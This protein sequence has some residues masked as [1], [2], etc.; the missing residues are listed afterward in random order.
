MTGNRTAEE[1]IGGGL[2][3]IRDVAAF[4]K[5]SRSQIY[6]L[7]GRGVLPFVRIGRSRRVPHQAVIDL[8]TSN[9]VLHAG[10]Q[11]QG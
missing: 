5:V 1:L 7:M 2:D 9:L 6:A 11:D 3:R 4:L 10:E 8:A